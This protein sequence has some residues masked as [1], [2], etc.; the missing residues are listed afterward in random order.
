[1]K[2]KLSFTVSDWVK[3]SICGGVLLGLG[4]TLGTT[5]ALAGKGK[6]NHG[7]KKFTPVILKP[8]S[9][10]WSSVTQLN[11]QVAVS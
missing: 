5:A 2:L 9:I 6:H 4:M 8:V 1:M 10:N 7:F 11:H 3:K